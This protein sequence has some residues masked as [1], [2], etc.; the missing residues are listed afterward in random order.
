MP[1]G[2]GGLDL[3]VNVNING[4]QLASQIARAVRRMTPDENR[5]RDRTDTWLFFEGNNATQAV[6]GSLPRYDRRFPLSKMS[7]N[8]KDVSWFENDE[9]RSVLVQDAMAGDELLVFDNPAGKQNDDWALIKIKKNI[10]YLV[11]GTFEQNYANE[12]YQIR[13][14]RKNGLDGKISHVRNGGAGVPPGKGPAAPSAGKPLTGVTVPRV[15]L[16]R[17]AQGAA[18]KQLQRALVKA[19]VMTQ[20]QMDTGPGVFGPQTQAALKKFQR[21]HGVE[22]IGVYGPKTRAAFV[23]LGAKLAK[24][25]KP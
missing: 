3:G 19:R 9:A 6:V 15:D 12:F 22:A 24:A 2:L 7:I 8:V 21:A 13:F 14:S 20:A 5:Y 25:A 1:K 17:G 16:Q 11:I 23:R 10:K 4:N 18:V